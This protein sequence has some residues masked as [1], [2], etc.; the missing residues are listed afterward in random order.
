MIASR[1]YCLL[2]LQQLLVKEFIKDIKVSFQVSLS[3]VDSEI[4][5]KVVCKG[6]AFGLYF[7]PDFLHFSAYCYT[8][9]LLRVCESEQLQILME[10]VR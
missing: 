10:R 4:R 3:E 8:Y 9:Y 1:I 6:T 5:S 7:L 2:L